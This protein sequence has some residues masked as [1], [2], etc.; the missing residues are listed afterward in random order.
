LPAFSA[1]ALANALRAAEEMVA[2]QLCQ[3]GAVF[4]AISPMITLMVR[5]T[6]RWGHSA[7]AVA[8]GFTR[9]T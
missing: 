9:S 4:A 2:I 8:L 5:S 7:N 3:W 1:F 6:T